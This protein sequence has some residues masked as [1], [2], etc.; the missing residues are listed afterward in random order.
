MTIAAEH[1]R[2]WSGRIGSPWLA[3]VPMVRIALRLIFRR[4][5]FWILIGLGL[6]N[7]LFNF[8]FIYMKAVLSAQN[9]QIARF[10][11]AYRVTGTGEAYLDFM[12]AQASITAL[13]L[14][15]AGSTL[16]GSDYQHG[17]LVFYLSRR[18]DRRHYV[19]GK[20]L[21]VMTIVTLITTLP[22]LILFAQYGLMSSSWTYF[23]E[24][25]RIVLGILGYGAV[26][27]VMQSFLLFAVA[28][29]LPRT[30][31]L[32]MTWLGLFVLLK[33]LAEALRQINGNRNWRLI[34]LW[35]DMRLRRPLVLWIRRALSALAAGLFAGAPRHL[36]RLSGGHSP[37]RAGRRGGAVNDGNGPAPPL[38]EF[39]GV[40]KW[41]GPVIGVNQIDLE[42]APGIT[43]LLGPN[44]AGKTTFIKLLTGLLRPSIGM[45]LV[46]GKPSWTAAAR[47]RIGY[48]PDVDALYE[49]MSGRNFV[50]WMARLHGLDRDQAEERTEAVL[51]DVGMVDRA[52][53]TLRGC[54]KGMRQRIRLAQALVHDPELLVV[55]EPL[56]GVDP[57]GRRELMELFQRL[58][59]RG[60]AVLV[61]SH[62]LEEMD[63]LAEQVVFMGRGRILATGSLP[64]I[65]A[66]LSDYPLKVRI[67]CRAAHD[68]AVELVGWTEVKRVELVG[69]DDLQLEI[70]PP[71]AFFRR[72]AQHVADH[73]QLEVTAL[74]TTDISA[75]AIFSYVLEAANRF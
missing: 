47:R 22:A 50:R 6:L 3:C 63:A 55:D 70:Q 60:K 5:V 53:R 34:A 40:T 65:R 42:L 7:F 64:E 15:F 19:V 46:R 38:A 48:C 54:S 29:C 30:V 67:G 36:R 59:E 45:A 69:E 18:I 10:L 73:P 26:L 13:L 61:S 49:E 14:A 35:D 37:P 71:E 9:E 32:V 16:I 43:G 58:R 51:A 28:A 2:A 62:I 12:V 33:A 24:Q 11:D 41:Y 72:F 57:V 4:W 31:P 39:R 75:E 20:L 68:L 44:G 66:M 8:A 17:G 1:Y 23:R 74:K 21:A 25:Y 27:A 52:H 56:N